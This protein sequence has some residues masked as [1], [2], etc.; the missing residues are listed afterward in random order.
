MTASF[1]HAL[2][3]FKLTPAG[4]GAGH[5]NALTANL[6][7]LPLLAT[8]LFCHSLQTPEGVIAASECYLE[9][10]NTAMEPR[11]VLACTRVKTA[12]DQLSNPVG[13][14]DRL[15]HQCL[16]DS[17]LLFTYLIPECDPG[18][19]CQILKS[20]HQHSICKNVDPTFH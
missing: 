20:L 16:N 1:F 9:V 8:V 19:G 12:T 11:A 2:I 13:H 5:I 15:H 7:H 10:L 6:V 3:S 4:H 14:R 18:S 17:Y